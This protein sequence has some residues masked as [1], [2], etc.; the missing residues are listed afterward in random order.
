MMG[1]TFIEGKRKL[2]GLGEMKS[3][4]LFIGWVLA[5][6]KSL[7]LCWALLL[8][9][10][11]IPPSGVLTL[12]NWGFWLLVF[13]PFRWIQIQISLRWD[14]FCVPTGVVTLSFSLLVSFPPSLSEAGGRAL[15]SWP[16]SRVP[17][18]S[19]TYKQFTGPGRAA[20]GSCTSLLSIC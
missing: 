17:T 19:R 15:P 14:L 20:V 7:L 16:W 8:R 9:G 4:W 11:G 5:G 3:S 6:E 13:L 12:F 2:G 10:M 18:G 1:S